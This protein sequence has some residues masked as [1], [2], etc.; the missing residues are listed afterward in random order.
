MVKITQTLVFIAAVSFVMASCTKHERNN[1]QTENAALHGDNKFSDVAS[2][3][4][5][6]TIPKDLKVPDGNKLQLVTYAS[7]VQIYQ[8]CR[9]VLDT[10]VF[11]WVNVAPSA[12]LYIKPDFTI[13]TG[14]HYRGPTWEFIKGPFKD[15]KAV[16][17]KLKG[18]T[19]NATAIPWLLLKA[20][21]S[22]SSPGNKITFIQ[23]VCTSGGLA[24]ST[25]PGRSNL[26][27][28]DSI[29]YTANYLFYIK[30]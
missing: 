17:M 2:L 9:S 19:V 3:S 23:R 15:G 4:L 27:E 29:P 22:L 12:T 13:T 8:V 18:I 26:G 21:D 10:T 28:V 7:G 20:V 1:L 5:C 25:P 30:D 11:E 16:G 24:P 14:F 6:D